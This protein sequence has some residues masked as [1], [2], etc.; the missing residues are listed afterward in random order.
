[1]AQLD[2]TAL[3]YLHRGAPVPIGKDLFLKKVF[4]NIERKLWKVRQYHVELRR[5]NLW[6]E[7]PI[8]QVQI[9]THIVYSMMW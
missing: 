8:L 2:T 3:Q 4:F 9:I 1:M 5:I 7:A 6:Y